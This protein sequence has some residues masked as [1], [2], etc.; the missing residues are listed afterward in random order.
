MATTDEKIL[1]Q[2]PVV[3]SLGVLDKTM[4]TFYGRRYKKKSRMKKIRL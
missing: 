1:D 3:V 2:I 4:N